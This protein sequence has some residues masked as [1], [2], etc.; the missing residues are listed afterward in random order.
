MEK[1]IRR[2][3]RW[4]SWACIALVVFIGALIYIIGTKVTYEETKIIPVRVITENSILEM[5]SRYTDYF[6]PGKQVT[7]KVKNSMTAETSEI[8]LTVTKI[9]QNLTNFEIW[10]L[11][12][13]NTNDFFTCFSPTNHDIIFTVEISIGTISL[14]NKFRSSLNF[15]RKRI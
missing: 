8:K 3:P 9:S 12:T 11:S 7:L 2:F 4:I 6:E 15:A 10:F 13:D 1:M 5:S 14:W